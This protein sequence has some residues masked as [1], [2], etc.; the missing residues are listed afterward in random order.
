MEG[1]II[2][3][4]DFEKLFHEYYS[5][6]YY[7]AYDFTEDIE[8]SKDIVSDVFAS[9]WN[10]RDKITIDGVVGYMFV[11]VRNKS[12]NYV[13]QQRKNDD[14]VDFCMHV[15][16]EENENPELIDERIAEMTV[17]IEKMSARTKFILEECY[18]HHKKYKEVAELLEI[19][20]S[21]VKKHIV[22]AFSIL[23]NHFNVNKIQN[24]V[25]EH[26]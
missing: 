5:R 10:G 15:V 23:R 20:P 2:T 3:K 16:E 14:Y 6:L 24:D 8:V 18:F 19:S 1:K 12:L 22:K 25:P 21:G 7:F 13:K 17:E 9:V 4:E 11:S 26:S